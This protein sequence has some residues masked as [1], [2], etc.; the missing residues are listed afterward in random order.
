MKGTYLDEV[1]VLPVLDVLEPL[2][3]LCF[4]VWVLFIVLS[5]EVEEVF[6]AANTAV[7]ESSE[8][9]RAPIIIFFIW[10]YLLIYNFVLALCASSAMVANSE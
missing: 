4:L 6:C 5:L 9:P 2:L 1:V 7:P 10:G 3:F 8:R